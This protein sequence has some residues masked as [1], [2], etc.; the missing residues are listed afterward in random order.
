[1]EQGRGEKAGGLGAKTKQHSPRPNTQNTPTTVFLQ[2]ENNKAG[3]FQ[4][5]SSDSKAETVLCIQNK[6]SLCKD[7]GCNKNQGKGWSKSVLKVEELQTWCTQ[8]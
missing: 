2:V 1:M 6:M 3:Q 8:L 5:I 7:L 4:T